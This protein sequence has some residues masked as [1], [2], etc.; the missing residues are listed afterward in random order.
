MTTRRDAVDAAIRGALTPYTMR[1]FG[2]PPGNVTEGERIAYDRACEDCAKVAMQTP[3]KFGTLADYSH[4]ECALVAARLIR[5]LKSDA[6]QPG[7]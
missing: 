1:E 3:D 2:R 7:E 5:A 4:K 6:R